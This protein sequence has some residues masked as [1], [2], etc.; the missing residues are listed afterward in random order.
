MVKL[1]FLN[2]LSSVNVIQLIVDIFIKYNIT[3][4]NYLLLT[5][6]LN[7]INIPRIVFY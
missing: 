1:I 5:K 2:K 6:N 7:T 3:N 4:M